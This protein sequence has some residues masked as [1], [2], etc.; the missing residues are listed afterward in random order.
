M[1]ARSQDDGVQR[2]GGEEAMIRASSATTSS[3]CRKRTTRMTM[4]NVTPSAPPTSPRMPAA[5]RGSGREQVTERAMVRVEE[6]KTTI[7]I[8]AT[9]SGRI[10]RSRREP[11]WGAAGRPWASTVMS[12]RPLEWSLPRDPKLWTGTHRYFGWP[13]D[14]RPHI[15]FRRPHHRNRRAIYRSWCRGLRGH[16]VALPFDQWVKTVGS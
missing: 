12:W 16:G 14:P 15:R 8:D 9:R 3:G 7:S 2:V 10:L 13:V 11:A 1:P 6:P 5:R 4:L